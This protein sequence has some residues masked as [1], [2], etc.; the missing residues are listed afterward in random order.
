MVRV[1]AI[2]ALR[3]T[4]EGSV[5][6]KTGPELPVIIGV[7]MP[8]ERI[9]TETFD[10]RRE[11]AVFPGDLPEDAA[12][13][14]ARGRSEP[15]GPGAATNDVRF[16]RFRPPRLVPSAAEPVVAP[17]IRLDRAIEFL[18]GDRLI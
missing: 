17:H 15:A 16:V 1:M 7:P 2:A 9:G 18:I 12:A 4:R 3:A 6:Q 13:A 8:G 5:R 11:A 14:I 10:G